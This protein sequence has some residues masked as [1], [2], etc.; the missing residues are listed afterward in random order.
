MNAYR[1][2]PLVADRGKAVWRFGRNDYYIAGTGEDR[3]PADHHLRATG[4]N[5]AGLGTGML[6]HARTLSRLEVA[7]EEGHAGTVSLALEL[8]GGDCALP[9]VAGMQKVETDLLSVVLG[10]PTRTIGSRKQRW[11]AASQ[12]P[13]PGGQLLL[14]WQPISGAP[15]QVWTI[16]PATHSP[17]P[18]GSPTI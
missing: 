16:G 2:E 11:F 8:D 10:D 4:A 1:N 3:F 6:M 14:V 17:S 18:T 5:E 12:G 7:D 15:A 9:L 13:F